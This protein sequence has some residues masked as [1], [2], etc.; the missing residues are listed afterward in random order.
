MR[1]SRFRQLFAF[2]APVFGAGARAIASHVRAIDRR[3]AAGFGKISAA[4]MAMIWISAPVTAHQDVATFADGN[5]RWMAHAPAGPGETVIA[6]LPGVDNIKTGS[7]AAAGRDA[8]L[9]VVKGDRVGVERVAVGIDTAKRPQT[10]NRSLKGGRVISATVQRPPPHFS[11]GSV[12]KRSSF[13]DTPVGTGKFEMA[14]VEPR[15]AE[16]AMRIASSF[17]ASGAG[18]LAIDPDLPVMVASLV[19]ESEKSVLAYSPAPAVARSPFAAVLGDNEPIS[20]IPRLGRHDHSWADDPLPKNSFSDAQQRCLA[21]AIYFEARGEPVRGQAAVAQVVLNRVRNPAY[22]NTICGVVYQNKNWR[23]RC[24]FSFACD[25]I[26]D[27]VN[28]RRLW[29]LAEHVAAE[30]TA[31]RIWLTDVGSSTH[32][33]ATYVRPRWARSMKRVGRIGLHIFYRT[34]GGGWS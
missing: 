26:R 27:R 9:S 6:A 31:G 16:E 17:H 34:L 18:E 21:A 30:T 24:Q 29:E 12:V 5:A 33:H 20:I 32:Y 13:L 14:F 4:A 2:L 1:N 11:A 8:R 28:N 7:V 3:K 23:N 10:V 22:P 15:P 19:R 25:R